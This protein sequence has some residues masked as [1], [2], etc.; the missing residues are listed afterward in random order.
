MLISIIILTLALLFF[1]TTALWKKKEAGGFD[2]KQHP[3]CLLYP[4]IWLFLKY[5]PE[6]REGKRKRKEQLKTLSLGDK[7]PESYKN[8]CLKRA[9][10]VIVIFL[11]FQLL[12]IF[13]SVK[14]S[15]TGAVINN[16]SIKRPGYGEGAKTVPVTVE[17]EDE[18][19]MEEES[20]TIAV[21]ERKY[22]D[23]E[24]K[25]A[26][27]A[28]K[29]Y[30]DETVLG[31]NAS[32]EGVNKPLNLV[33][34][35]PGTSIKVKW[36]TGLDGL[37]ESD[38]K[39]KELEEGDR[40]QIAAVKAIFYH[41]SREAEYGFYVK[42]IP[43]E[44]TREEVMRKK[45]KKAIE[46][47]DQESETEEVIN[48]PTKTDETKIRF[49]EKEDENQGILPVLGILAAA[50]V[51]MAHGEAVEKKMK[52]RELQLRIDYPEII[53]KF[54]LLLGAGMTLSKAWEKIVEEYLNQKKKGQ[55][56]CRY[57]YEEM[58]VTWHELKNGVSERTAFEA[59]GKR[60][61]LLPYL[62]WGAL[63]SQNVKKGSKGLLSLL[64]LEAI[65][66][67]QERK[68]LAKRMGEEAGTKLL[69]PMALMLL[70]VIVI[71]MVP[72]LMS[73]GG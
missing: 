13:M 43:K 52:K 32:A 6:N 36:D 59:F 50:A 21:N 30:I 56:N 70:V 27:S 15:G 31:E 24:W 14:N 37:I 38:G 5:F 63:L 60:V 47:A 46:E 9:A 61:K 29:A 25:K 18:K 34:R 35:I 28:A 2:K 16:Q 54:T 39:V 69:A 23:K 12:S 53:N 19:G 7:I 26:V 51:G 33:K 3:F 41:G 49:R 72:A 48:L 17:M 65:D 22:G 40:G 11:V 55:N 64:E 58:A 10:S 20:I 66:A 44:W 4:G 57:A 8:F 71:V 45:V 67:F 62:K 73:F 42:V 68:E 1:L